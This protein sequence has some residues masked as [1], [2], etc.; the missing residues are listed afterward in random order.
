MTIDSKFR[1]YL[2]ALKLRYIALNVDKKKTTQW[3]VFLT[4]GETQQHCTYIQILVGASSMRTRSPFLN[5]I[6]EL[7][8]TKQYSLRT[9]DTY[10]KWISSYIHYHDKRHPAS[11][12]NNEVV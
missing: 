4:I 1:K 9:F 5:H 2:P 12:G 8:L 11:M 3:V 6:A 7:M 10:L